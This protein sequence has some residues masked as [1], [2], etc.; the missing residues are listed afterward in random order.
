MAII[1]N[2]LIGRSSQKLGNSVFSTQF[3]N[4]ILKSKPLDVKNPRTAN[5]MKHRKK[6]K[7][8]VYL[9]RQLVP[10][11][12]AAYTNTV[13]GMSPFNKMVAYNL[14]NAYY[15]DE[16]NFSRFKICDN[17]GSCVTDVSIQ[18]LAGHK[19]HIAW[20][21]NTDVDSKD[22]SAYLDAILI[23]TKRYEV[24]ISPCFEYR[25]ENHAT[26]VVPEEWI[27]DIVVCFIK[28]LDYS[29]GPGKDPKHIF[30]DAVGGWAPDCL[31]IE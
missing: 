9:M 4:N 21:P 8:M 3:G 20:L 19:L 26:I 31:I 18:A 30:T 27:G 16:I 14:K 5:Q 15:D 1:Q 6:F 24:F 17:I 2:P 11:L 23:N 13:K 10:V 12:N 28:C 7:L 22:S 25:H 29:A